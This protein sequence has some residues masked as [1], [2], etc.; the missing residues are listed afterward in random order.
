MIVETFAEALRL[1]EEVQLYRVYAYW[2]RP[3]TLRY[4]LLVDGRQD[5]ED[6]PW[7]E[8]GVVL[9]AQGQLTPAGA[10]WSLYHPLIDARLTRRKRKEKHGVSVGR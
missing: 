4:A 2:A 1:R 7:R 3:H 5:L 6:A 10:I 8:T 9:V